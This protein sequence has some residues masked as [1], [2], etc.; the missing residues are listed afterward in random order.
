[1]FSLVSYGLLRMSAT[2]SEMKHTDM[3][4]GTKLSS[5]IWDYFSFSSFAFFV[6]EAI[7]EIH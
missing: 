3:S 5:S 6:S 2:D 1:M 7:V 4:I